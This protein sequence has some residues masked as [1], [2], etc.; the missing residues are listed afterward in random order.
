MTTS[1]PHSIG[2]FRYGVATVESTMSGRW[3][4]CATSASAVE[5][6][7][8]AR[9]VRDRLDEDQLG[10]VGDRG[11]VRLRIGPLDE[12]GVDAEP[13]QGDVELGDASAVER[14]RGDDV[15]PG[16]GERG[17]GDELGAETGCRGDRPEAAL[18]RGD[19][20]LEAR[21][22]RVREAAVDVAVLLQ[23]EAGR[24]I[25]GVVEDERAGLV[26]RQ[27]AGAVH[28]VGDV[29]GVDGAGA[30]APG[31]VVAVRRRGL[32]GVWHPARLPSAPDAVLRRVTGD[33]AQTRARMRR[34]SLRTIAVS[35]RI[36]SSSG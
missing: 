36:S 22:R 23:G 21:D 13:A 32:G 12:R 19:A 20:L 17:E 6:G 27:R 2:R 10:L 8:L 33:A 18:E 5:V 11:G 34:P 14:R 25:R 31:A 16:A 35:M 15:V 24:G 28:G 1:A 3:C 29:A 9:R 26:D 7:D 30:E 4:A